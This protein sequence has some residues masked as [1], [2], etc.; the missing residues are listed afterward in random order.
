MSIWPTDT[1]AKPYPVNRSVI[2]IWNCVV[3]RD[4]RKFEIVVGPDYQITNAFKNTKKNLRHSCSSYKL[5]VKNKKSITGSAR[6][7]AVRCTGIFVVERKKYVLRFCARQEVKESERNSKNGVKRIKPFSF[8]KRIFYK[9]LMRC[10]FWKLGKL[11][12]FEKTKNFYF[13]GWV[14]RQYASRYSPRCS[15]ASESWFS[16][17]ITSKLSGLQLASFSAMSIC[18]FINFVCVFPRDLMRRR[19]TSRFEI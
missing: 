11:R 7:G 15:Q 9:T 14:A 2:P 4:Q 18:A 17:R 10:V 1:A 13:S 12:V 16:S 6:A 19:K 3:G 8:R 5:E